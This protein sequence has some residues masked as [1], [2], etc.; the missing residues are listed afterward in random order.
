MVFS[1]NHHNNLNLGNPRRRIPRR[2]GERWQFRGLSCV[3]AICNYSVSQRARGIIV[4]QTRHKQRAESSQ[5]DAKHLRLWGLPN[6]QTQSFG[7][8]GQSAN[9]RVSRR[10]SA[11]VRSL[12]LGTYPAGV[13]GAPPEIKAAQP[14]ENQ[15]KSARDE[16]NRKRLDLDEAFNTQPDTNNNTI[17]CI[18]IITSTTTVPS[19]IETH[20]SSVPLPPHPSHSCTSFAHFLIR[21]VRHDR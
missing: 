13:I 10:W 15:N 20:P 2:P 14:Q 8:K 3:G 1:R 16:K 9:G 19:V 6:C 5:I 12:T 7:Q 18:I 17:Q 21:H 11:V 4:M